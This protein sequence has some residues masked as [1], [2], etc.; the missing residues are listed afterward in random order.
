MGHS[1]PGR[2]SEI[3]SEAAYGSLQA[4]VQISKDTPLSAFGKIAQIVVDIWDKAKAVRRNEVEF[5]NLTS[6]AGMIITTVWDGIS[7]AGAQLPPNFLLSAVELTI[8]LMSIQRLVLECADRGLVNR[9]FTANHDLQRITD[10][11][12]E[13][14]E[15][16]EMFGIGTL[17]D[18]RST[19]GRIEDKQKENLA[20][21]HQPV[22]NMSLNN[23]GQGAVNNGDMVDNRG[24]VHGGTI[25]G[26]VVRGNV[27][28]G[29]VHGNVNHGGNTN[30]GNG[31]FN[32]VGGNQYT[33]GG[34]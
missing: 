21:T 17:I 22:A 34:K 13:L 14:D 18:I 19:V 2:G 33:S 26:D 16:K 9:W 8:V 27:N 5:K 7:A 28:G 29:I 6:K 25:H 23:S 3:L 32:N 11:N 20:P 10:L 12:R 1:Q 15:A 30:Y 31:V 4:V 24:G